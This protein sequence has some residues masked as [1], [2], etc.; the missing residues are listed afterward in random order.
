M[1]HNNDGDLDGDLNKLDYEFKREFTFKHSILGL[2]KSFLSNNIAYDLTILTL[3]GVS[4]WQYEPDKLID[5][6]NKRFELKEQYF[7]DLCQ[8]MD[9]EKKNVI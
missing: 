2:N 8:S 4:I 7:N 3:N 1:K 5:L 9:D 6:I